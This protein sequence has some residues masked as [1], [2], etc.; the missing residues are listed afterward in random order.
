MNSFWFLF[1]RNLKVSFWNSRICHKSDMIH[2]Q[3][4]INYQLLILTN[5]DFI[6]I[7]LYMYPKNESNY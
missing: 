6:I 7:L 1:F 3:S 4:Q 5:K 2:L